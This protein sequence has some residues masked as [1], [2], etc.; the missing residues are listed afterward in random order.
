MQERETTAL[1][2]RVNVRDIKNHE[3]IYTL[4]AFS[5]RGCFDFVKIVLCHQ[6]RVIL[7]IRFEK[8]NIKTM[9]RDER[10]AYR[11]NNYPAFIK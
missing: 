5:V 8:M 6:N 9:N 10:V 2:R 3:M 7:L 11:V 1:R 4:A